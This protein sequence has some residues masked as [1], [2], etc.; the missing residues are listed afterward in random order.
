MLN[1][2]LNQSIALAGSHLGEQKQCSALNV[3]TCEYVNVTYRVSWGSVVPLDFRYSWSIDYKGCFLKR[4]PNRSGEKYSSHK[5]KGQLVSAKG[6]I[7][8]TL[9]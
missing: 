6:T 2:A 3:K 7:W 9:L 5:K 1:V 4:E 8:K